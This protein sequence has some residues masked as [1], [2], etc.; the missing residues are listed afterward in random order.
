VECGLCGTLNRDLARF[1]GGCGAPLGRVC[2]TC[3]S[4]IDGSLR[5]CDQC[6][7]ALDDPATPNPIPSP[8]TRAPDAVRKTVTVLFADLGGSTG[9]GERTD[10]EVARQ[11]LARYHA[12]L[13]ESIDAHRGTV[14]KFM[15]DGM[16]ATFGIPEVAEDD[17]ERA[18]RAGIDIQV[19][20][21]RFAAHVESTYGETLTA[22]VGINTG[23]IVIAAADAD[24][25]GDALNVAARLEKACRPGQVL[26]GDETWRLTRGALA[27]ESLGEVTVSGRT[28]PVGTYEVATHERTAETVAPFV[29]RDAE[30]GRLVTAFEHVRAERAAVLVTVIGS[31]GLGKTRLSRELAAHVSADGAAAT[32]EIRCDRSGGS[33]FAPIADLLRDAA[34]L[35]ASEPDDAVT[36]ERL[37]ALLRDD[38]DRDRIVDALAGVLG[39]A[40]ARSVEETFWAVR[41]ALESLAADRPVLVV[42]DDI[43]WA[44]PKLLDLIDHLAEWVTG[45]PLLLVG[46]ARPELRELRPAFVEAGRR[47]AHVVALDGLDVRAT[48]ALAAGLLG[49]ALPRELVG[50]LPTSTD[51]NPLFVRELVRMLVDDGVL[52]RVADGTWDLAIDADAVEVPPT[53]QSL[54]AT[55]V[56]RLP[57]DEL[58]TLELAS[59]V[60]A[61][62]SVGALQALGGDEAALATLLERL[63]RKELVEPTG[64]YTAGSGSGPTSRRGTSSVSTRPRSRSTSSRRTGTGPS[65]G[66]STTRRTGWAG[67][68]PISCR[69]RR[70]GR[71]N[72]T[73][74]RPPARWRAARSRWCRSPTSTSDP[75]S[76]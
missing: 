56:E 19:R 74:S 4:E 68:P 18:V 36:H 73:T 13:Q 62:F 16:M 47:V 65:W 51:G 30:L 42:I 52:R 10:P 72:G 17:A 15:G 32:Y 53:I 9:F 28:Q 2:P 22:R 61:E 14:A 20:F 5:F 23:E 7:T 49:S 70:P 31:P 75:S 37:G 54:L 25:V 58:R 35:E 44:E 11:V 3:K 43:Q 12:F 63:R 55:R 64:T 38:A 27:Y 34:G 76:C 60:G 40:P 50:R 46:L 6:G 33:T 8:P 39:A 66:C 24:L 48:E 67:A 45:V 57:A 69:S 29:G 71:W 1:C 59:V 21:A 26:V 41:R